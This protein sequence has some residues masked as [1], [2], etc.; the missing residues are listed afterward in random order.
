MDTVVL[1]NLKRML[2]PKLFLIHNFIISSIHPKS[3]N[4]IWVDNLLTFIRSVWIV[5]SFKTN[6][7]P[8]L[9]F[10]NKIVDKYLKNYERLTII[11]RYARERVVFRRVR[12]A[13]RWYLIR[14]D[15]S[16]QVGSESNGTVLELFLS[17]FKT[18]QLPY[19]DIHTFTLLRGGGEWERD[20]LY[21]I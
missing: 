5:K 16:N 21:F 15:Y 1:Q 9:T 3:Y 7:C 13:D 14:S 19:I 20:A 2:L 12:I 18:S 17:F 4:S 6:L 8:L 10:A 11:S